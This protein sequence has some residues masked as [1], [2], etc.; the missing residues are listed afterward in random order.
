MNG[1]TWLEGGNGH[2]AGPTRKIEV[3]PVQAGAQE[4]LWIEIAGMTAS[5]LLIFKLLTPSRGR[6]CN[7]EALQRRAPLVL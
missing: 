4:V 2:C 3:E 7:G 5:A 1:G 6:R